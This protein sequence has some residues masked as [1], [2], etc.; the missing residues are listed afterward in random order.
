MSG[1]LSY[2]YLPYSLATGYLTEPW[3]Y[4]GDP[5]APVIL[6]SLSPTSLSL[7]AWPHLA[8]YVGTGIQTLGTHV[9]TAS[10]LISSQCTP[11]TSCT[12]VRK[13]IL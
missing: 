10:A 13:L 9:F 2:V 1:G 5:Q 7:P 3:S 12:V 4:S 11:L 8:F 6:L